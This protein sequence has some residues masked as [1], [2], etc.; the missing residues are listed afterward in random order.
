[1]DTLRERY[2]HP[3]DQPDRISKMTQQTKH[4]LRPDI[5]KEFE[6]RLRTWRAELAVEVRSDL[7]TLAHQSYSEVVGEVRDSGD[8]SNA[9]ILSHSERMELSRHSNALNDV[10]AALQRLRD[11]DFG[12]CSDCGGA[13]SIERLRAYPTAMRCV[14]C[15]THFEKQYLGNFGP[16]L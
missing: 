14:D 4:G 1:M 8:E 7:E 10:D 9:E 5:V 3:N 12:V 2:C 15:Q 13:I 6:R 16:S 11:G